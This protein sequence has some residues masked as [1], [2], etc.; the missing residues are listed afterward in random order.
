MNT[1]EETKAAQQ[2][3]P[4]LLNYINF[5]ASI[6]LP[7]NTDNGLFPDRVL[8][9]AEFLRD[10]LRAAFTLHWSEY[11]KLQVEVTHL[12]S[13]VAAIQSICHVNQLP[14]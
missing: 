11:Q 10:R 6:L 9:H 2:I 13:Q 7:P 5:Q 1:A 12:R 14:K 3:N 8:G 4:V